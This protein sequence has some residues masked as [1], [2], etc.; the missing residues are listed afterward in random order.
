MGIS[1]LL[2]MVQGVGGEGGGGEIWSNLVCSLQIMS[3]LFKG[4]H[5]GKS[6]VGSSFVEFKSHLV[7]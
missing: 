6:Y 7:D 2:C 3:S 1:N 5:M 4:W